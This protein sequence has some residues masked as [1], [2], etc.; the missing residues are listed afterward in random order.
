LQRCTSLDISY[1]HTYYST[2]PSAFRWVLRS[3]RFDINVRPNPRIFLKLYTM[4]LSLGMGVKSLAGLSTAGML[5]TGYLSYSKLTN[6]NGHLPFCDAAATSSCGD[7]LN[8]PYSLVPGLDIPL[9]FCAFLSYGIVAYLSSYLASLPKEKAAS[10]SSIQSTL[11]AISV[12]MGSFSAYLMFILTSVLHTQCL[13]CYTSAAISVAMA[14][15]AYKANLVGNK[16]NT[17]V[18]GLSSMSITGLASAFL[19]YSTSLG[20]AEP[21]QA[22]TAPMAQI[23]AAAENSA[24]AK[25]SPAITTTSSPAAISLATKLE[26][27]DATMYGAYWCSHC[28]NQKQV[29]DLVW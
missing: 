21:A 28:Y 10:M 25:A 13:Y 3:A 7:V 23:I 2:S 14:A 19:F 26:K 1:I 16:T 6:N 9:V 24:N 4:K 11:L 27:M 18:I 17:A 5:E 20:L 29:R 12:G 15:V 22:S 8:G